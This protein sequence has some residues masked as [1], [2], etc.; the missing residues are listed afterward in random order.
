[1][2]G[3]NLLRLEE[4]SFAAFLKLLEQRGRTEQAQKLQATAQAHFQDALSEAELATLPLKDFLAVLDLHNILIEN[5]LGQQQQQQNP[6]EAHIVELK[7][8]GFCVLLGK[9][10]YSE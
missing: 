5:L 1:M 6:F 10:H 9:H 8:Q 4:L 7:N 3:H 2:N